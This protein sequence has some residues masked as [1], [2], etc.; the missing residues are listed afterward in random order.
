M[1]VCNF[2]W[3]GASGQ[4]DLAM[5]APTHETLRG[6]HVPFH[7][8]VLMSC[9]IVYHVKTIRYMQDIAQDIC[10]MFLG[11]VLCPLT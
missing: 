11:D 8:Y 2:L 10:R 4:Y 9:F 5:E 3:I 7:M 1:N 6:C